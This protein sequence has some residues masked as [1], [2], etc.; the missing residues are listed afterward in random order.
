[1][2]D[3][4]K[5]YILIS[6]IV[7]CLLLIGVYLVNLNSTS[8]K[9]SGN[10]KY[11]DDVL[12]K[13]SVM[14]INI[15]IDEASFEDLKTNATAEEYYEVDVTINGVTYNSVGIRA[16]G[17]SSLTSIARDETTDRYSFK[18]NFDK[19]V[20]GQTYNGIEKYYGSV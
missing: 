12:D 8:V 19:Y 9:N 3:K 13:N 11:I 4:K 6:S 15:D 2:N 1:M 17:N 18:L 7:I 5:K 10:T 14:E 20:D 16:K